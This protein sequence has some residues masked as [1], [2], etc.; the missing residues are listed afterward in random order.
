VYLLLLSH[1]ASVV[2]IGKEGGFVEGGG[3][4]CLIVEVG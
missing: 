2:L 1:E 3:S 4:E